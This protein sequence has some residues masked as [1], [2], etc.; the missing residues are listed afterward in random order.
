[1]LPPSLLETTSPFG[2]ASAS[3]QHPPQHNLR[4]HARLTMA[5]FETHLASTSRRPMGEVRLSLSSLGVLKRTGSPRTHAQAGMVNL[6][7]STK[8]SVLNSSSLF[9]ISEACLRPLTLMLHL[10]PRWHRRIT[11]CL[12]SLDHLKR[13]PFVF[14]SACDDDPPAPSSPSPSTSPSELVQPNKF[15]ICG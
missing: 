10:F 2:L 6:N 12:S 11:D 8:Y 15:L 13:T 5:M 1:M 9:C 7:Y 14:K 4:A 3:D